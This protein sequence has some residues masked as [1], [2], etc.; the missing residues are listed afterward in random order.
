MIEEYDSLMDELNFMLKFQDR[1]TKEAEFWQNLLTINT[2][3]VLFFWNFFFLF[4]VEL[5]D[6]FFKF[7]KQIN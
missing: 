4:N 6:Y 1:R 3:F 7:F 5:K 2:Q